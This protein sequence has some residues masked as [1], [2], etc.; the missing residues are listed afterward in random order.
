LPE[1]VDAAYVA[2]VAQANAAGL[3][4]LA[5]APNPPRDVGMAVS[6]LTNDTSLT[7]TAPEG[8]ATG[9][10]VVWR[11]PGSPVWQFSQ[12]VGQATHVTLKG[13]SKD[14]YLFGVAAVNATGEESLPVFPQPLRH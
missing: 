3:A 11:E 9:Y 10:R 1:L 7:W 12:S 4:S 14:N 13:V 2:R 8:G 6:E 5:L